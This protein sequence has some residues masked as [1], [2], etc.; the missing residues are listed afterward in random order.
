[1]T[2]SDE[3]GHFDGFQILKSKFFVEYLA[4]FLCLDPSTRYSYNTGNTVF[5]TIRAIFEFCEKS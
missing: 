1:M 2:K 4:T 3:I 5:E